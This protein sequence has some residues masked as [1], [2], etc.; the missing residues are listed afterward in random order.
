VS[1]LNLRSSDDENEED[2]SDDRGRSGISRD[3]CVVLPLLTLSPPPK[4]VDDVP[5]STCCGGA[6]G[7]GER[8]IITALRFVNGADSL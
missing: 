4:S 2:N 8:L 7:G 3:V 1:A 6:E 5:G